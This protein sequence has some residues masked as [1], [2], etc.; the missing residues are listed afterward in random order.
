MADFLTLQHVTFAYDKRAPICE[1]ISFGIEP[2]GL[3]C[4]LGP[5]GCGK[6]TILRLIAGFE[7]VHAGEI[8]I[9]GSVLSDRHHCVPPEQRNIGFVFQDFALF[10]HLTVMENVQFGLTRLTRREA[11]QRAGEMLD[12]V[13]MPEAGG[14]YPHELSGGQRQRVALARALAPRPSLMLLDEPFS[15]L[16]VDLRERLARGRLEHVQ[17]APVPGLRRFAVDPVRE[18]EHAASLRERDYGGR[19]DPGIRVP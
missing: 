3:A 7:A 18:A 6:T 9:A 12:L 19:R 1:D 14:K 15:S 10:P 11:R 8:S 13:R 16:D 17:P 2:D 5:S 4:L